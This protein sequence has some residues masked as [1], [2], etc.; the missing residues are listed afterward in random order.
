MIG[1]DVDG[2]LIAQAAATLFMTG[3]IWFVQIVHYPLLNA[4][5]SR[6]LRVR[7]KHTSE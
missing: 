5:G 4:S 7:R 3:L 6:H 2:F 1:P